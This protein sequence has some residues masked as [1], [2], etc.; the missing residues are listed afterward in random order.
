MHGT[1]APGS[2]KEESCLVVDEKVNFRP[3]ILDG[4]GATGWGQPQVQVYLQVEVQFYVRI[5]LAAYNF[6]TF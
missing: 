4:G 3:L 6:N 2:Y 5:S 1:I